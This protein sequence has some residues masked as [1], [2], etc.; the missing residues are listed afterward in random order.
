[1]VYIL[2]FVICAILIS[3]IG[4]LL[5][6]NDD[7]KTIVLKLNSQLIKSKENEKIESELVV[8]WKSNIEVFSLLDKKLVETLH[9]NKIVYIGDLMRN[10]FEIGKGIGQKYLN[11]IN[12]VKD[13]FQ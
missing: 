5:K 10:D 3:H 2:Y 12:E 7:Y 4:Y 13:K 11:Q 9:K 6:K 1:M 8:G